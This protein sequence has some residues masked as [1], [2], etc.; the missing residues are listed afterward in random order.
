M[1]TRIIKLLIPLL[2]LA[3]TA[4]ADI[5]RSTLKPYTD[6]T[7]DLGTSTKQWQDLYL[8]GT[9]YFD[10]SA[11]SPYIQTLLNDTS[12]LLAQKTLGLYSG[13]VV[14]ART[15]NGTWALYDPNGSTVDI[16]A[17]TTDG[18]QEGFTLAFKTGNNHPFHVYGGARGTAAGAPEDQA[19]INCTTTITVP[20]LDMTSVR[21]E[22]VTINFTA[23]L[24]G[25]PG[26]IIDSCMLADF[27]MLGS[28]IVYAGTDSAV[29][30]RP[31][32]S[33]PQDSLITIAVSRFVLYVICGTGDKV[34]EFDCSNGSIGS[35]I[36]EFY[37]VNADGGHGQYI[38][39][40]GS[41]GA[42][43]ASNSITAHFLHGTAEVNDSL[44]E[45]TGG[46]Y[47]D[48][49]IWDIS[50]SVADHGTAI[51][52]NCRDNVF[53]ADI[54]PAGNDCNGVIFGT[55]S[56]RNSVLIQR[57]P[58]SANAVI[59]TDN[60]TTQDNYCIIGNRVYGDLAIMNRVTNK[61]TSPVTI[62]ATID[63]HGSIITNTGAPDL[64]CNLPVA[65]V[66]MR[67]TFFTTDANDFTINPQDGT[68]I[69]CHGL[70]PSSG[71]AISGDK[72]LGST[73]TLEAITT[74]KWAV[75]DKIGTW[76]DV[77]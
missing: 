58:D 63:C 17:S 51:D 53:M 38:T 46:E 42:P 69:V 70:T 20:P 19:V 30:F 27:E 8:S 37:E 71:D 39:T 16:S 59:F 14:L 7:Y 25:N 29:V 74:T 4:C 1:G 76:S 49:S 65:V 23:A 34:I 10:G 44:I 40:N 50:M 31:T 52:A 33:T 2:L 56:K 36:F 28:Q 24:A 55:G 15:G 41:V 67:I 60:S 64:V 9:L 22:G 11:T 18:L 62:S 6:D 43:F 48:G 77:D 75:T 54:T 12:A 3:G 73:V 57:L 45:I 35:N 61:T 26:L 13:T 5:V 32:L 72:T 47:S 66:G 68:S 21:I